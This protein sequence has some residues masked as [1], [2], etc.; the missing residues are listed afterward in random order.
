MD[1]ETKQLEVY[2]DP[3]FD[4]YLTSFTLKPNQDAACLVFPDDVVAWHRCLG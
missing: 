3:Q 2:R 1:V 4:R